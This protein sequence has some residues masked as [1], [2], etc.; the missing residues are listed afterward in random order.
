MA[1]YADESK[2][3]GDLPLSQDE[4]IREIRRA[5]EQLTIAMARID[6]RTDKIEQNLNSLTSMTA[7]SPSGTTLIN[8]V[9][10]IFNKVQGTGLR[11]GQPHSILTLIAPPSINV[12]LSFLGRSK[13]VLRSGP[14]EHNDS[15]L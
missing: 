6:T 10:Q 2:P 13:A 8:L 4:N 1:E 7:R 3:V 11:Q 9:E 14:G 15:R 12:V 5:L